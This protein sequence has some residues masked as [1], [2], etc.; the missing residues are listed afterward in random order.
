MSADLLPVLGALATVPAIAFL[1][2]Y[3]L[4][5]RRAVVAAVA[6]ALAGSVAGAFLASAGSAMATSVDP[7]EAQ[8]RGAAI[9]FAGSAAVAAG[10][11]V[12]LRAAHAWRQRK[13]RRGVVSP[14]P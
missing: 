10:L 2:L 14:A 3:F 1:A 4:T 12:G 8:L 5:G 13:T 6:T 11:A 7:H 9:G